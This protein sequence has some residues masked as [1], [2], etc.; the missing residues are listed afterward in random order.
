M[1]NGINEGEEGVDEVTKEK[2]EKS[3]E[4]SKNSRKKRKEEGL[5]GR[6][7]GGGREGIRLGVNERRK[8][9]KSE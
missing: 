7:V 6:R 8:K 4:E 1:E 9:K 5:K 2:R 3:I